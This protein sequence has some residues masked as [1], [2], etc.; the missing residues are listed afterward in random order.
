MRPSVQPPAG[1]ERKAALYA[2]RRQKGKMATCVAWV[3]GSIRLGCLDI[4]GTPVSF[5]AFS[6]NG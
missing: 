2:V 6:H 5:A 4:I 1:V 3:V